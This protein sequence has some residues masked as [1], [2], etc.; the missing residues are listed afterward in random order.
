M[1]AGQ[2]KVIISFQ[3]AS[4]KMALELALEQ[5]HV[6]SGEAIEANRDR[7]GRSPGA[8]TLSVRFGVKAHNH[9][10]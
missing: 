3:K 8:S 4:W 1:G 10:L 9:G 2:R 7:M 5:F 6:W